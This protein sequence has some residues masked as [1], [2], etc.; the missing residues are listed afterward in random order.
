LVI[1]RKDRPAMPNTLHPIENWILERRVIR[2]VLMSTFL[3]DGQLSPKERYALDLIAAKDEEIVEYRA[4]QVAAQSFERNGDTRL[5]RDR[6]QAA[7]HKLVDLATERTKRHP[8]VVRFP[9][10]QNAG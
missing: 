1:N 7:G 5:T 4:R 3:E 8:N 10:R 6:F 2:K 9:E